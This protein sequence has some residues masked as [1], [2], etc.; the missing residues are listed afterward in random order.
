MV[1]MVLLLMLQKMLLIVV[2]KMLMVVQKM[3]PM[4][5]TNGT[6]DVDSKD[7]PSDGTNPRSK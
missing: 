6:A 3:L 2:E 1:Q 4:V 7:V 5:Y